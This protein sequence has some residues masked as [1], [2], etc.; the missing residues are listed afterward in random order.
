[1]PR[2]RPHVKIHC[3]A[4]SH[5]K[6]AAVWRSND[7]LATWVRLLDKGI[8]QY[9][10]K[11]GGVVRL[12][13]TQWCEVTGKGRSDV[14]LKSLRLLADVSSISLRLHGDIAE[15]TIPKFAQKQ[16]I[17]LG[18]GAPQNAECREQNAESRKGERAATRPARE[19]DERSRAE[20]PEGARKRARRGGR[21]RPTPRAS[22][23]QMTDAL[24]A[25]LRKLTPKDV[26]AEDW[27]IRA[28][29]EAMLPR[30]QDRGYTAFHRVA[31]NWWPRVTQREVERFRG[32]DSIQLDGRVFR[33]EDCDPEEWRR[34][35]QSWLRQQNGKQ[36]QSLMEE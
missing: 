14:A 31:R 28:W 20:E 13:R 23:E 32:S 34:L 29:F 30:W 10:A 11:R 7:L 36:Q 22:E 3:T 15:I 35:R 8:E 5:P 25:R 21:T 1:M 4:K 26:E 27:V 17:G 16:G 9:A 2:L 19:P 6:T 33:K 24:L 12:N 18:K